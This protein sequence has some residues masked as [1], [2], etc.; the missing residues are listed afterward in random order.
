M[1]NNLK[2]FPEL[3][4]NRCKLLPMCYSKHL[5]EVY[6]M[7]SDRFRG[8]G[9][10]GGAHLIK[11]QPGS[12]RD[13]IA[14][15]RIIHKESFSVYDSALGHRLKLYRILAS[16]LNLGLLGN[17]KYGTCYTMRTNNIIFSVVLNMS[18]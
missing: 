16:L 11:Y 13:I 4:Q 5:S 6:D 14:W 17:D 12:D 3:N 7:M 9:G 8:G 18:P 1:T 10:G 2:T 15:S